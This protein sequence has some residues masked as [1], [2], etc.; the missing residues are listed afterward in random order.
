MSH[1]PILSQ[2]TINLQSSS[3]GMQLYAWYHAMLIENIKPKVL[4]F[5]VNASKHIYFMYT[6]LQ[7][8]YRVDNNVETV[9]N[10][11]RVKIY[12]VIIGQVNVLSDK[13]LKK[14]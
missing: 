13:D 7:Q 9:I 6:I 1:L 5:K 2:T 11:S 14:T 10:I 12:Y 3:N 4:D 8:F